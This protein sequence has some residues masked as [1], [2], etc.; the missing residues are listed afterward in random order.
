[1]WIPAGWIIFDVLICL[2]TGYMSQPFPR[3]EWWTWL[4]I[5]IALA[6]AAIVAEFFDRRRQSRE[7]TEDKEESKTFFQGELEKFKQDVKGEFA[8]L[9]AKSESP[10]QKTQEFN[11][12][13]DDWVP[14]VNPAQLAAQRSARAS[15]H[16]R[17]NILAAA[18]KWV[19][20]QK[21]SSRGG[22]PNGS[23]N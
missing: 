2:R 20:A 6:V 11:R 3:W 1:M 7:R 16:R 10:A 17:N 13:I 21:R 23:S 22:D 15:Q 5:G 19:D 4:G 12:R 14:S 8:V 18:A 9:A